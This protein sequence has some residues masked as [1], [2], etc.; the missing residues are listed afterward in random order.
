[1]MQPIIKIPGVTA[2]YEDKIALKDVLVD[3]IRP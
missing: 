2:G 1:M 3:R